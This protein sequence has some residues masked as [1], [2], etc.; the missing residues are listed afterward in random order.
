MTA[1]REAPWVV[2]PCIVLPQH[3]PLR[4]ID[5]LSS[6]GSSGVAGRILDPEQ[7][8]TES[9]PHPCS[10]AGRVPRPMEKNGSRPRP[11]R[12]RPHRTRRRPKSPSEARMPLRGNSLPTRDENPPSSTVALESVG[13]WLG[14]AEKVRLPSA[15]S[16]SSQWAAMNSIAG[17]AVHSR[18]LS[19]RGS[20]TLDS[21]R[22]RPFELPIRWRCGCTCRRSIRSRQARCSA[23]QSSRTRRFRQRTLIPPPS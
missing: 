18:S 19:S 14:V 6:V 8:A 10:C 4:G 17:K 15:G 1:A 22:H 9:D 21:L 13:A 11:D 23:P 5:R 12:T 20:P 2:S 7:A 3:C 16:H